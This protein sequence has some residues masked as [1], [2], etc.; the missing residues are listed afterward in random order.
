V[1]LLGDMHLFFP[2]NYLLASKFTH[3]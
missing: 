3:I 2:L 1:Q